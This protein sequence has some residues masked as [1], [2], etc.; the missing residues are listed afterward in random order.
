MSML[1]DYLTRRL[2]FENHPA[3]EETRCLNRLQTRS[4]CSVCRELC[5]QGVFD[6]GTPDWTR[7]DGCGVCA[8]RCP[9]RAIRPAAMVSE[10]ILAL[11]ARTRTATVIRCARREDA[12]DLSV[13][14]LA[15]LPWE[16]LARLAL[17][18][19]LTVLEGPCADCPR[20]PLQVHWE[21]TLTELRTALGA[22]RAA[23]L[24]RLV[25]AQE[26]APPQ[27][28]SRREA[29][30]RLLSGSRAA[31]AGILPEDRSLTP[32]G[33]LSRRLLAWRLKQ[34][35]AEAP[36]LTLPLPQFRAACNGCGLCTRLCP[37]EALHRLSGAGDGGAERSGV[38]H[39]AVIPWRCTGCDLCASACPRGGLELEARCVDLLTP[40]VHT[41]H[42]AACSRCGQPADGEADGLCAACRAETGTPAFLRREK[43]LF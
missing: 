24:L 10:K 6:A 28:L 20:R 32:D 27:G 42:G 39:M 1:R 15:A 40:Q 31:A 26:S 25:S 2:V 38:W 29:F 9:S 41:V 7:C 12:A 14:C 37:S 22:E 16:L 3:L 19:T 17:D 11:A 21:K 35:G 30:S 23:S 33:M 13:P 8:A 5:P 36:A 4:P 34:Q 43:A 18:G